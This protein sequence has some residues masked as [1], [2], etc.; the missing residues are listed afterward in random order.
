MARTMPLVMALVVVAMMLLMVGNQRPVQEFRDYRPSA[1]EIWSTATDYTVGAVSS[2]TDY[3]LGAMSAATDA[4]AAAVDVASSAF[5]TGTQASDDPI[6][7]AIMGFAA[8]EATRRG[9]AGSPTGRGAADD[10]L[11]WCN[12]MARTHGVQVGSTWGTLGELQ[13]KEWTENRCDQRVGSALSAAAAV[14]AQ[15]ATA[16]GA[17]VPAQAAAAASDGAASAASAL[18]SSAAC[19]RDHSKP[20]SKEDVLCRVVR[21]GVSRTRGAWAERRA[22]TRGRTAPRARVLVVRARPRDLLADPQKRSTHASPQPKGELAFVALANAAY[23]ELALNWAMLLLPVLERV[24]HGDRAVLAALDA[25]GVAMFTRRKLP[26]IST[27]GFGGITFDTRGAYKGQMD[28]FRWRTGAFREY[29]VTK[30][31]VIIWLLRAGRDVCM[32][33]VDA[34]WITPPY[35]LLQS[36]PDADVLSGTDCLNVPWDA[37]RSTRPNH[38]KNCGHQPGSKWSAWFNTGVMIFRARPVAID[39]MIEWRN[40]MDAIKGDAQIDDQLTFNQ[41]VGTVWSSGKNAPRFKN[42]YPLKAASADGRVIF[43]GNGTRKVRGP[44]HRLPMAAAH[45]VRSSCSS[46]PDGGLLVASRRPLHV[47]HEGRRSP[48]ADLR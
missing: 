40:M 44:A 35:A 2:A 12:E 20:L 7:A 14:T 17:A 42:F 24:G 4:A 38:V 33:D 25:E 34:A 31:E 41:L 48:A 43:D 1:S 47:R 26:T 23:G 13:Q 22:C 11:K 19:N 16:A 30:A 10:P 32:S 29:G 5:G 37:D 45:R 39:M 9:H 36:V 8:S 21:D 3:T 15:A 18:T 27:N 46:P 28:G 6:Q